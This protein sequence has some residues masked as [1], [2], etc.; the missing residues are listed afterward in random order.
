MSSYIPFVAVVRQFVH[1]T[2]VFEHIL[3]FLLIGTREPCLENFLPQF[4]SLIRFVS[5][6][7]LRAYGP[8]W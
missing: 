3:R 6:V 4:N 5:S 2:A 7:I 8:N 1:K